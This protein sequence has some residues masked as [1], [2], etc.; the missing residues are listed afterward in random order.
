MLEIVLK[1]WLPIVLAIIAGII[2]LCGAYITSIGKN[3]KNLIDNTK[4]IIDST[5]KMVDYFQLEMTNADYIK[6]LVD[7]KNHCI[8][9]FTDETLKIAVSEVCNKFIETVE[10]ILDTYTIGTATIT[11]ILNDLKTCFRKAESIFDDYVG[12][13]ESKPFDSH[14][15]EKN[16]ILLKAVENLLLMPS[17]HYTEKIIALFCTFMKA[18]IIEMKGLQ[19]DG[20]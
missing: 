5:Q 3:I 12:F 11:P 13:Y 7:I 16:R 2:T 4:I 10:A 19:S 6:K 17:N 15:I 20:N 8:S 9:D 18:Y 14:Q 1:F